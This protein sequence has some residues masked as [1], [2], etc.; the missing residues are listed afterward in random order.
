LELTV[1]HYPFTV[2]GFVAPVTDWEIRRWFEQISR[3]AARCRF[4]SV[5]RRARRLTG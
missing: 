5:Y 3:R 1:I 4:F 2:L